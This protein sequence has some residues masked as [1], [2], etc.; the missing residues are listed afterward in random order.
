MFDWG[1]FTAGTTA[2]YVQKHFGDLFI[3]FKMNCAWGI[4]GILIIKTEFS[5]GEILLNII[6]VPTK[7]ALFVRGVDMKSES[8]RVKIN[9]SSRGEFGPQSFKEGFWIQIGLRQWPK[10]CT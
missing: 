8:V 5:E 6:I 10:N 3:N 2:A 4:N 7:V 9:G 1:A